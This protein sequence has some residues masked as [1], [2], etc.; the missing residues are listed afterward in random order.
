M[1]GNPRQLVTRWWKGLGYQELV[2]LLVM[3]M[4]LAGMWG[5]LAIAGE[6][7]EGETKSIDERLLLA[8][9]NPADPADPLGPPWF[10]EAMR[11]LTA[12]G[13]SAVLAL[14]TLAVSGYLL[15]V[16]RYLLSCLV[17]AAVIGG[18]LLSTALKAGYE[19]PRPELVPHLSQVQYTSFPSGH[20]MAAAATYLTLGAL[21]AR[22]QTRPVL[23]VYFLVLAIIITLLVGISRVYLG[24]HWP[25]DVVAGWTAGTT[26]ALFC[27][28]IA[29]WL[30]PRAARKVS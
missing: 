14:L 2:I 13:G 6:V 4:I 25:T 3:L 20:S 8:L 9:R 5:F 30:T 1:N 24:V 17:I 10:E 11:D 12:L 16:R 22:A 19:R 21:L 15:L 18:S 7:S 26:W 28:L 27:W 29:R 23:H